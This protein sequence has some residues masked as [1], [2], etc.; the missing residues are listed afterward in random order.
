MLH[1]LEV[2][3]E[4]VGTSYTTLIEDN[5]GGR[6]EVITLQV[7]SDSGSAADLSD[8]RLSVKPHEDAEY[9]AI[10]GTTDWGDTPNDTLLFCTDTVPNTLTASGQATLKV[11]VKGWFA[12]KFDAKVAADTADITARGQAV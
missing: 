12:I 3:D 7:T 10:L 8:F 4:S 1:P 9:E 11:N 2:E 5:P 6:Y